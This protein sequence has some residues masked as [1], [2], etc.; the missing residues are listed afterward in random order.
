MGI[1]KF[2]V[3]AASTAEPPAGRPRKN[4]KEKSAKSRETSSGH[5]TKEQHLVKVRDNAAKGLP[6]L[7]HLSEKRKVIIMI[8]VMCAM[9]LTSLD[10]T[11]VATAL[12]HIV[13]DFH[14]FSQM[15]WVVTAY[16]LTLTVAIPISGKIS[17]LVGR[18]PV[19]LFGVVIFTIASLFS[20]SASSIEWLII[21]RAVQGLGAGVIMA[22]AFTI[23]GDLFTPRERGK[24]QGL[25]SS[26]FALAAVAGPLIG[27]YFS[28]A[29]WFFGATTSWRWNFWLNVPIGIFAFAMIAIFCPMIKHAK[30]AVIDWLGAAAIAVALV[31]IVLATDNT[32]Q[33]FSGII[34]A[35]LGLTW[36]R[37]ILFAITALA[38]VGFIFAERRAESPIIPLKFFANR[39]F[40]FGMI[41]GLLFGA[42]FMS[43]ILYITQFNQQVF[44]ATATTSGLMLLPAV[45]VMSATSAA[46]G[47]IVTKTG[48]YKLQMILGF[49][50]VLTACLFA[51][52][53]NAS[54]PYWLE[55]IILGVAGLGMGQ[56]MPTLNLAVQNSVEQ[57]SIGVAT[58]SSQL[59]RSLG[60]TIGTAIL[61]S[62]LTA[63]VAAGL[64]QI[65][66]ISYI[67]NIVKSPSAAQVID[68]QIVDA[69]FALSLNTPEIQKKI[70][71]GIDAAIKSQVAKQI[72]VAKTA[73]A[74][75]IRE[76]VAAHVPAATPDRDA[77]I[78]QAVAPLIQQANAKIDASTASAETADRD[79]FNESQ[80][81]FA[82]KV[83]DSFVK[84]LRQIFYAV[85]I[86]AAAGIFV[87]GFGIKEHRLRGSTEGEP[88]VV[89]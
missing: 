45:L 44:G 34:N 38:I 17:D 43:M 89:E 14:S 80:K 33:I 84:E 67:E 27:G 63:G 79:N 37:V 15:S 68:G 78:D 66:K 51:T 19:L 52:T 72:A 12:T 54:S 41:G 10:Q 58:S 36:V 28:D 48:R 3:T 87:V 86:I 65:A 71:S 57:K 26:I 70:N 39:T 62:M 59:F 16:M 13:D 55:A 18:K 64:G 7:N 8:A 82:N 76:T 11:I 46:T 32:A 60:Q 5:L 49:A 77:L 47:I 6:L 85:C 24:W 53:L 42:A 75:Q 56:A 31:A 88:G 40:T 73:T 9:F 21:S 69:D 61:G 25:I 81:A 4:H 20:G 1:F 22:N 29:N 74:A 50:I 35:G 2:G 83:V 30:K 23:I